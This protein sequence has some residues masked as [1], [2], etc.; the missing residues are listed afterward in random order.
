MLSEVSNL[1]DQ[2]ATA[3]AADRRLTQ[4]LV[5][6]WARAAR[7]YFPSWT[8]MQEMD[9]GEDWDWVFVVDLEQSVGFPYFIFLGDHLAKL[10][11][12]H[13]SGADD[14]TMSMLDKVLSDIYASVASEAPHYRDDILTLCDGRRVLLRGVTAPLADDGKTV[15][16][17]IGAASGK[18]TT[19]GDVA[20]KPVAL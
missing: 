4:R 2:A 11:N 19:D 9:L 16:H 7:G 15:T 8:A 3:P 13:L 17:V 12:V 5:N 14:W 10:S 18:F 1:F 20:C 6:A